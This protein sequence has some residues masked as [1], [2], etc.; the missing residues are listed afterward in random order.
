[1]KLLDGVIRD[2]TQ[3]A[4]KKGRNPVH[5]DGLISF[6][7]ILQDFQRT[8][9]SQASFFPFFFDLDVIP[10]S[11]KDKI[12]MRAQ[13]GITGPT[14][15]S[16]DAFQKKRVAVSLQPLKK[17]ERGLQVHEELLIDGNQVALLGEAAEF[18]KRRLNHLKLKEKGP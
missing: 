7:Q 4:A 14:L 9:S 10:A 8:F 11:F 15:A 13:E 2:I 16:L 5:S 6:H 17:R 1:M 3:G 12:G 18:I